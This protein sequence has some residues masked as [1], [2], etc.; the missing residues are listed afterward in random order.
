MLGV[1]VS[2]GS[3]LMTKGLS[4]SSTSSTKKKA[5]LRVVLAGPPASGKGTQCELIAKRYGLSHISTGDLLRKEIKARSKIGLLAAPYTTSGGLV[6]DKIVIDLVASVLTSEPCSSKGWLLDGFPR[7][8]EQ[9]DTLIS[10]NLVPS[11]LIILGL[12]C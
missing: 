8:G 9:A 6:P 10:L 7:T 2:C 12:H 5:P 3:T 4:R 1:W 11:K